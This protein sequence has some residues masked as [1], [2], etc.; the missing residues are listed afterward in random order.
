MDVKIQSLKFDADRKLI[1]FVETKIGKLARFTDK[2]IS[3]EVIL[4]LDK[5]NDHGNK[6]AVIRVVVPGEDLLA[7]HRSK[8]FEESVDTAIDALKKQIDKYKERFK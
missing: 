4:R 8:T 5:D 3:S 7:E 2:I 6:V 1:E